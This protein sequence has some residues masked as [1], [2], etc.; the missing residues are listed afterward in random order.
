MPIAG[1]AS[2]TAAN[3]LVFPLEMV[4]H[5]LALGWGELRRLLAELTRILGF[6]SAVAGGVFGSALTG[7]GDLLCAFAGIFRCVATGVGHV[8]R[9][10]TFEVLLLLESLAGFRLQLP[11]AS[12]GLLFGSRAGSENK[13][14][15]AGREGRGDFHCERMRFGKCAFARLC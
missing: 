7:I 5:P 1:S 2:S 6:V 13:Q 12:S 11:L 3:Y 9:A 8:F 4:A 14:R 15:A 10:L